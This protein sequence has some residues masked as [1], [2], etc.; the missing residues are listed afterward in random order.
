[1][2]MWYWI[3]WRKENF[4]SKR[5]SKLKPRA[6]DPFKVLERLNDNAYKVNFQGDYGVLIT[7]NVAYLS[8]F[9]GWWPPHRFEG[10]FFSTMG[11]WWMSILTKSSQAN[12]E[13]RKSTWSKLT[14]QIARHGPK[15]A[16]PK[17]S[18]TGVAHTKKARFCALHLLALL[19]V[20]Y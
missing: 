17:W 12:R 10:K 11:E 19:W 14:R 15:F 18:A 4:P 1:M 6:N 20:K 7:V 13:P 5:K 3:H 9:G 16:W 8:P 2:E